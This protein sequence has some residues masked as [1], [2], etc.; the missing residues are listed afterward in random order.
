MDIN[1]RINDR[2]GRFEFNLVKSGNSYILPN[3]IFANGKIGIE[4][5]AHDRIDRSQFRCGINYIELLADSTSIFTQEIN[6]INFEESY[7]IPSLMD[8]KS[9]KTRGLR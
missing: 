4:L 2:F 7:D 8:F 3:P 1:S 5:L 9:L 6:Q